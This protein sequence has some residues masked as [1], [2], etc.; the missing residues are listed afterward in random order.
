MI[1]DEVQALLMSS[2]GG[3][4]EAARL[5]STLVG[6]VVPSAELDEELLRLAPPRIRA[7]QAL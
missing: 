7:Q 1:P 5:A 2:R 4:E 6:E 3:R